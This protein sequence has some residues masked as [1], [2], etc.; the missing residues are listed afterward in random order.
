MNKGLMLHYKYISVSFTTCKLVIVNAGCVGNPVHI[1]TGR[2][3]LH[4]IL[5]C[6]LSRM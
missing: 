1:Q 5:G 4:E 3:Q 2:L 6:P